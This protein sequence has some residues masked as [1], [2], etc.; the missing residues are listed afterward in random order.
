MSDAGSSP[1]LID[2]A[3]SLAVRASHD[4]GS[5][6]R[7]GTELHP[8]PELPTDLY[9]YGTD[10]RPLQEPGWLHFAVI[11][12][13]RIGSCPYLSVHVEEEEVVWLGMAG[14]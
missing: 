6:V 9:G 5:P 11:E 3:R 14:E 7:E 4:V 12:P 13:N 8:C 2:R 10:P 1:S